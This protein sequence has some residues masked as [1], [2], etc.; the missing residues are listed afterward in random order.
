MA[1]DHRTRGLIFETVARSLESSKSVIRLFQT[2]VV[3]W[4]KMKYMATAVM[5]S[6]GL[7]SGHSKGSKT[8]G[9]QERD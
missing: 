1:P 9:S 4:V 8:I 5:S 7:C 6:Q 2:G 3:K